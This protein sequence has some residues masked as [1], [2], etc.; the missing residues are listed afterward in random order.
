[1]YTCD[2]IILYEERKG[3]ER[4]VENASSTSNFFSTMVTVGMKGRRWGREGIHE[5]MVLLQCLKLDGGF[6][7][8]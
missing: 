8:V 6:M 2:K 3:N 7:G 1:M 4:W 5:Q